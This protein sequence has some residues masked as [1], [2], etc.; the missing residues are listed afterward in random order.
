[1]DMQHILAI[2]ELAQESAMY[3]IESGN[4]SVEM[5]CPECG[6]QAVLELDFCCGVQA[7]CPSCEFWMHMRLDLRFDEHGV[8]PR[9]P[10]KPRELRDHAKLD[11]LPVTTVVRGD[12]NMDIGGYMLILHANGRMYNVC[13][14][15][16]IRK[17]LETREYVISRYTDL[18]DQGYVFRD[19]QFVGPDRIS[20]PLESLT[21]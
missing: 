5:A 18:I 14:C 20:L 10:C 12:S 9:W 21:R 16:T 7:H 1:M 2:T 3:L 15:K 17:L 4:R 6:G 13:E 19:G 11:V 8:D